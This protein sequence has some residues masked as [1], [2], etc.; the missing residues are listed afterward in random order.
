MTIHELNILQR[1]SFSR[2]HPYT[3]DE[4]IVALER[5]QD[6]II[7][8]ETEILAALHQDLGKCEAE[9]YMTEI[10]LVKGEIQYT[11][12]HLNRWAAPKRVRTAVSQLPGRSMLMKEPWGVVLI[13][14][15][16]NYPFLLS[17]MPFVGAL[18]AGN[19]IILK[20]S[21][22]APATS[23]VIFRLIS[24]C[25]PAEQAAV[26]LGGRTENQQLLEE[27]FDYIFFTGG[28]QVGQLVAEKAARHLTPI[29][30]ELGGKSPCIVDESAD[31]RLAARRIA[32][33][34]GINAGQTCVAPDYV[35]VHESVK[36]KLMDE[37]C[38][39]WMDFYGN[40]L[41][42]PHWP[43]MISPRH[44]DRAM[45][46]LNGQDI[47]FGGTGDGIRLSPTIVH[48]VSWASPIMQ[49]E[50]FA[51]ILPVLT[52]ERLDD[53]IRQIAAGEKPLA[54]YLFTKRA[55][56]RDKV[57]SQLSFGG[58]CINDTVMHLASC[59]LPFGGVGES[60]MGR[61][62]GKYSFDTFTHEKPILKKSRFPDFKFRYPPYT[63]KKLNIIKKLLK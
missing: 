23:Q 26:V 45:A 41:E 32:F 1:N 61:Y 18:A 6:A 60:G 16:W 49:E 28:K 62:H 22:Y 19:H 15:P 29:T 37:I 30:L 4:R 14:A 21:N 9:S 63:E 48:H 35:L 34:K 25:F 46:L 52:F 54:L 47:Y 55:S 11:I 59:H 44:Y 57:L 33:G 56:A 13:M 50:I 40:A 2:N 43:M 36:E 42:N 7:K 38:A 12:R 17:M 53:A 10:G 3:V 31:I 8:R 39:C 58:G 24:E 5:L 51:P 20:P 27:K